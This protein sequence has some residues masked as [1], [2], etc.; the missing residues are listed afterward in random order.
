M[1]QVA[2]LFAILLIAGF[3][4]NFAQTSTESDEPNIVEYIVTGET[5]NIRSGPG[6]SFS[7]VDTVSNGDSLLIYDETPEV[8]GWLRIYRPGEDDAFIADFL[9]ERAPMRYY[10]VDQEPIIV[11]TGTG[12]SITEVVDLPR[13][14]YR[15]D[16][17]VSDS[18]FILKS[19]VI[20]GNCRDQ[21][22]LNE[23]DFDTRNLE[24]SALLVSDGCSLIFETD[25]V[26]GSWSIE[27][28]DL[29]D[30]EYLENSLLEIEDSS[31]I[32]G[33]GKQLTMGTTIPPGIWRIEADVNDRSF[34]LRSH[35]LVGDCDDTAVFNE[36][37]FD[38]RSLDI[39][40]VYPNRDQTECIV[41]WETD[42][43]D[44]EWEI[45][46]ERLDQ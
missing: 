41:F 1:R 14:A 38:A 33:K 20:A 39:S 18:S 5:A 21:N 16:V 19:V 2:I 37:D 29:L 12:K 43:V 44:K 23:L 15:V 8:T 32:T 40:T 46:F 26:S 3:H 11:L 25:N 13:S 28:R 31:T 7:V 24:L 6:T 4:I 22:I 45:S 42:N 30:V 27:I 10:A 36:L 34:I 35:V 9:V 17:S